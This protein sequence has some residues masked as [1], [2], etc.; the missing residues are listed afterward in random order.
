MPF[1]KRARPRLTLDQLRQL[2]MLVDD[3]S[4]PGAEVDVIPAHRVAE[5]DHKLADLKALRGELLRRLD[6]SKQST[7]AECRIVEAQ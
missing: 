4:A 3:R 7:L 2:L 1:V 5:I 6:I